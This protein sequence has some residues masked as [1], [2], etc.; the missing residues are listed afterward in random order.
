M[1]HWDDLAQAIDCALAVRQVLF[2]ITDAV[3]NSDAS[4]CVPSENSIGYHPTWCFSEGGASSSAPA[5]TVP[6]RRPRV[7]AICTAYHRRSHAD[8]LLSRWWEPRPADAAW[9]WDGPRSE[10]VSG[11]LDQVNDDD[12][13]VET[14]ERHNIACFP[15]VRDALTLGGDELAVDGVLLVGEHGNYPSNDIGQCLYPR[16]E[17]FDQIVEVF[18]SS[19]RA[20]PVFCDKH[21]SWNIDW[22][23]EMCETA[24]ELRFQLFSGSSIPLCPLEPPIRLADTDRIVEAVVLFFGDDESYG[25]HSLEFFQAILDQ[26]AH[27]LD[28]M[29]GVT[30]WRG[31]AV[32]DQM[33]AGTWSEDLFQAA[34]DSVSDARGQKEPGGVRENCGKTGEG[35]S[36]FVVEHYRSL[37]ATHINLQGHLRNWAV[38]MRLENG[39]IVATSPVVLGEEAYWPHF[40]ALAN[41]VDETI[42]TGRAPHLL[43]RSFLT[44]AAVTAFMR[45]RA[46]PGVRFSTPKLVQTYNTGPCLN[47]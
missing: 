31:D 41:M 40:A 34:L 36:A 13:G 15:T 24:W 35:P 39:E 30:A 44:T 25:Y 43:Q 2:S 20:V 47:R 4:D 28:G 46:T 5:V 22:A 12:I 45:A 26:Q 23:M 8:V 33:E 14:F 10:L 29:A 16:K 27:R 3:S 18:R 11:Y 9:G 19:G 7:S 32:W 42:S 17:L 6:R 21:L 37:Q 38:A 1:V